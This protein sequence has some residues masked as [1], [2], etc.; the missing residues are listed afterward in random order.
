MV[1]MKKQIVKVLIENDGYVVKEPHG[2]SFNKIMPHNI[3]KIPNVPFYHSSWD[4]HGQYIKPEINELKECIMSYY[5]KLNACNGLIAIPSDALPVDIRMIEE[6]FQIMGLPKSMLVSKTS[7]LAING[8]ESYIALSVSERLV[9]LEWYRR[10]SI[11]ET[12][13]YNKSAVNRNKLFNDIGNIRYKQNDNNMN[14]FIFDGC[15]ELTEL[16]DIG[17]VITVPEM[18]E[19]LEDA[20]RIVFDPEYQKRMKARR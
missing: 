17:Q 15:N 13:F 1:D 4:Y 19:M 11:M 5:G 14:I 10:G 8:V 9:I 2:L 16:Y 6:T 3:Y 12:V 18:V 20:S 7:L